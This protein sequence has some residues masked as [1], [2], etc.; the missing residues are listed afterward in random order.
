[1]KELILVR[2]AKSDWGSELLKDVDRHL[3]ERGYSDAY[4]S[5]NWF[6]ENKK[7]PELILSSTATRALSTALIF[8]RTMEYDMK[9]FRLEK[10]IY[11]GSVTEMFEIINRQ[12]DS[13]NSL[14]L[15]GHNPGITNL[16]NLLSD[17]LFF[18]NVPTCGIL[19]F[20]FE[21]ESWKA[22]EPKSG[23]LNYYQFPKDFKNRD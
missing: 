10:D 7:Q 4:F 14:M 8:A 18:D 20:T 16:G 11:E 2:H 23:K 21:K 9:N 19:S 13:K 5:S 6:R 15:F 17:D 22:I 3:N 1:M 12:N